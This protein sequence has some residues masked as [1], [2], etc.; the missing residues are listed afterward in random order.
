MHDSSA[1]ET[2]SK[3]TY[4]NVDTVFGLGVHF[5]L[6]VRHLE[7]ETHVI[8]GNGVLPGKVLTSAYKREIYRC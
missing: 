1:Y 2:A 6:T 4:V 3:Y 7:L 5:P 8:N